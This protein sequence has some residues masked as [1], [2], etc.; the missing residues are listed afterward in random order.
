MN[1]ILSFFPVQQQLNFIDLSVKQSVWPHVEINQ[2][3]LHQMKIPKF[4][5][6]FFSV[7]H[8]RKLVD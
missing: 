4:H 7:I 1:I 3:V 2:P 5:Q 6:L 8:I